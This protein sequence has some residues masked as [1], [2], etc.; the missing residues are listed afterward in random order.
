MKGGT[1]EGRTPESQLDRIAPVVRASTPRRPNAI[2]GKPN[3]ELQQSAAS[4]VA[5]AQPPATNYQ[6]LTRR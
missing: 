5:A 1:D 3:R 6:L 4:A 2:E